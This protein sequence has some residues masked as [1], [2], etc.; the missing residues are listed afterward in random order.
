LKK[1][2]NERKKKF[3]SETKETIPDIEHSLRS[4]Y[5]TLSQVA[6]K[7][8]KENKAAQTEHEAGG[9]IDYKNKNFIVCRNA[10]ASAKQ[11]IEEL[12]RDV[13][14]FADGRQVV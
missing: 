8:A 14:L 2:K 3:H 1:E 7:K 11:P 9:R 13:E 4:T 10:K 12:V 5:N 6:M